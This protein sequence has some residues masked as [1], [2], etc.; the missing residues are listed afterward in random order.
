MSV[1]ETTSQTEWV[2][3]VSGLQQCTDEGRQGAVSKRELI[4]VQFLFGS[5]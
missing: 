5:G 1:M 3:D 4:L 2:P